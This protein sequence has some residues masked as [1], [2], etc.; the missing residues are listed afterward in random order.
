MP[1]VN[2]THYRILYST[3]SMS[4]ILGG[5]DVY[6]REGE[7]INLTCVIS[8]TNAPPKNIFWYH[9][10]KVI[11]YFSNRG[12]LGGVSIHNVKGDDTISQLLI[13]DANKIDEGSYM[14]DPIISDSARIRVFVLDEPEF[15]AWQEA[16][17]AGNEHGSAVDLSQKT[18]QKWSKFIILIGLLLSSPTTIF[19]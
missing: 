10:E 7:M 4:E 13:K 18:G 6:L 17:L 8:G 16:L 12:G 9:Q 11:S 2:E 5:P 19:L 14:C 15:L 1:S 3:A